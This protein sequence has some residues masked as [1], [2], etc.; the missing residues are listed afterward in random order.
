MYHRNAGRGLKWQYSRLDH[1]RSFR[2][3]QRHLRHR[4]GLFRD[5]SEHP[6]YYGCGLGHLTTELLFDSIRVHKSEHDPDDRHRTGQRRYDRG[7]ESNDLFNPRLA[8][9]REHDDREPDSTQNR[10]SAS[11]EQS[12]RN[13]G[14]EHAHCQ[15]H[16][17]NSSRSE[18][19][20]PVCFSRK[21]R[22]GNLRGF[23]G[24]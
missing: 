2:T 15:Q 19:R 22:C 9:K 23:N 1:C 8:S 12:D 6:H 17:P 18:Q 10:P 24:Y 20:Q 14:Y 5:E 4:C 3:F 16:V 7:H 13:G 11:V 21:R